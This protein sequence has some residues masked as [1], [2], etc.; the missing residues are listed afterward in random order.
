[1]NFGVVEGSIFQGLRVF[2]I[3]RIGILASGIVTE[4]TVTDVAMGFGIEAANPNSV[5]TKNIVTNVRTNGIIGWGTLHSNTV[6][7]AGDIGIEADVGSTVIGN[8]AMNNNVGIVANCPS[9]VT[10]NTAINNP[11]GNLVLNGDGCN[12]TNN[13]AP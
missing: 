7:G 5:V 1:M 13:V 12:N 4:N 2:Q 3:S 8:T 6:T 11:G 10:D 9:N